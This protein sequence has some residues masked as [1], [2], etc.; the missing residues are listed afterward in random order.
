MIRK[1]R[2]GVMKKKGARV[3]S[4]GEKIRASERPS[5]ESSRVKAKKVCSGNFR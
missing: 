5:E 4:V 1:V 2:S 3:S